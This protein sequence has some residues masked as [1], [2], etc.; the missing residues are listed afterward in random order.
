MGRIGLA[1]KRDGSRA[2]TEASASTASKLI[3]E[4]GVPLDGNRLIRIG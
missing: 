2:V 1:D 3:S 4:N